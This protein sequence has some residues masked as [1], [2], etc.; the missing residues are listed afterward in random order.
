[1]RRLSTSRSIHPLGPAAPLALPRWSTLFLR[2]R[3]L[4][5]PFSHPLPPATA[6]VVT[7]PLTRRQR[8]SM[9]AYPL[10][11]RSLQLARRPQPPSQLQHLFLVLPQYRLDISTL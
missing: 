3:A 11:R 2:L 7:L 5:P 1:M 10:G 8:S 6:L 4:Y 9:L